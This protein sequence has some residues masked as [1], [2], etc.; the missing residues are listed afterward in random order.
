MRNATVP[1]PPRLGG[2]PAP[3]YA[4]DNAEGTPL[5]MTD[6]LTLLKTRKSPKIFDLTSP[7]RRRPSSTR[8]S[9]SPRACPTMASSP[10]ALRHLRGRGARAGRRGHRG[11]LPRRQS[12]CGRGS[13]EHRA[14]PALHAPLVIAVVSKAG[15]HA[16]IPNGNRRFPVPPPAPCWCSPPTRSAMPRPGSPAGTPMMR[17]CAPRSASSRTSASSASCMSARSSARRRTARG[18]RSPT[19]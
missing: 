7:A 17:A 18:R 10:L 1:T 12:G 14:H 8:C 16:K 2:T 11:R 13:R 6:A 5:A 19:S 3:C 9:P 15:P 4:Q